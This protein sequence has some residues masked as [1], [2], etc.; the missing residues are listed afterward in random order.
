MLRWRLSFALNRSLSW[1]LI[2]AE[3]IEPS[4]QAWEAHVLPLNHARFLSPDLAIEAAGMVTE[5]RRETSTKWPD[6]SIGGATSDRLSCS[7]RLAEHDPS[8]AEMVVK[9]AAS[10]IEKGDE[11]AQ[12]EEGPGKGFRPHAPKVPARAQRGACVGDD[13]EAEEALADGIAVQQ[14]L[15]EGCHSPEAGERQN[16]GQRKGCG[17]LRPREPGCPQEHRRETSGAD[18]EPI[19]KLGRGAQRNA[20]RD[21]LAFEDGG[22]K[23][24]GELPADR[25]GLAAFGRGA[26]PGAELEIAVQ[27]GRCGFRGGGFHLVRV[28]PAGSGNWV[29]IHGWEK[30]RIPAY[31]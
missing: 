4:T 24:G 18:Q 10:G 13:L 12:A 6:P 29:R 27:E 2:R 17:A 14:D 5:S 28:R 31:F 9:R 23:D 16:K 3:G 8:A 19:G 30:E 1:F 11:I 22:G 7:P 15:V 20:G 25:I 21:G 26:S